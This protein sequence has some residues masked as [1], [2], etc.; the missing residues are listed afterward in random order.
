LSFQRTDEQFG[1]TQ[2]PGILRIQN[3]FN[4]H[5]IDLHDESSVYPTRLLF[6]RLQ[7][8]R[9]NV[10]EYLANAQHTKYAVIPLHTENEFKLFHESVTVKGMWAAPTGLPDFDRM[11][12]WWSSKADGKT[13]FYKLREHLA[14]YYK[15]W[16]ETRKQTESMVASLPQREKNET[17]I[18]SIGHISHVL[19]AAPHNQPGVYFP[20]TEDTVME[21]AID[22][23]EL[24]T[25]IE[26]QI[27]QP[28]VIEAD[29]IQ[30]LFHFSEPLDTVSVFTHSSGSS[31]PTSSVA[32]AP[33]SSSQVQVASHMAMSSIVQP[34]FPPIQQHHLAHHSLLL[35]DQKEKEKED[36]QYAKKLGEMAMIAQERETDQS[37]DTCK[38][39]CILSPKLPC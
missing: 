16:S 20:L 17:R 2:I 9:K 8:K 19:P 6:S 37:A 24:P 10:Y 14:T 18:R 27:T 32:R 28:V 5:A 22:V 21:M 36:V 7:G 29:K 3:D 30:Q 25:D 23:E 34:N 13:I 26:Q 35:G 31:I 38:F 15:T 33:V 11:A 12:A 39:E 1:I 4:S